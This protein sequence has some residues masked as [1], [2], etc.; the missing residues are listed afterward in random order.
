[1]LKDS[2][3]KELS[4]A[5]LD[6]IMISVEALDDQ[7][8]YDITGRKIKYKNILENVKRLYKFCEGKTEVFVKTVD[9]SIKNE[10]EKNKFLSDFNDFCDRIYIE[11]IRPLWADFDEMSEKLPIDEILMKKGADFSKKVC[12]S[13]FYSCIIRTN[14]D[15]SPCGADWKKEVVLGNVFEE[16]FENIW[17]GKKIK[18]FWLG[19]LRGNKEEGVCSKC[20]RLYYEVEDNIDDSVDELIEKISKK[21]F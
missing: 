17:Q 4:E 12:T 2:L 6:R 21:I 5:G 19:L 9:I 10:E 18:E 8:Y 14:G 15:V 16:R 1:M 11:K 3:C 7:G 13:A 20:D